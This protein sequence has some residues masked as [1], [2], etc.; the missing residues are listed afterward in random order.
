MEHS[1]WKSNR[2]AASEAIPRILLNPK[3]HYLIQKR[4]PPVPILSQPNL[5]HTPH[6]PLPKDPS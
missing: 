5:L 4:S 2:F 6:I 3:V 1:P